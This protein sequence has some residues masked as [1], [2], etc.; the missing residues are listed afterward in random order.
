M[1]YSNYNDYELMYL[2]SENNEDAYKTAFDKYQPLIYKEAIKYFFLAQ[3]L[4][5]TKE[6]LIEEGKIGLYRAIKNYNHDVEF[7]TFA[8]ICIKRSI[9]KIIEKNSTS[10]QKILN[11]SINIDNDIEDFCYYHQEKYKDIAQNIIDRDFENKIIIF[12]NDL[13]ELDSS[14]FELKYNGFAYKEI[15]TLLNL[16]KKDVDNRLLSIRNKLKKYLNTLK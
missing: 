1:A 4:G 7:Y 16:S 9:L 12:K 8:S 14:I 5:I 10:K 2:I 11:E 13:N 3:K 15:A 6:D